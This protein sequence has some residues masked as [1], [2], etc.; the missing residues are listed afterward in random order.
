M[1]LDPDDSIPRITWGR[2][3]DRDGKLTLPYAVQLNH[4][5]LDGW[6]LS[7]LVGGVQDFLDRLEP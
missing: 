2:Y 4:R 1:D 7:Q 5:L 3:E 6:H